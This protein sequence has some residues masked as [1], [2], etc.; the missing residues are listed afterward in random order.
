MG[1]NILPSTFS[2]PSDTE[3]N[4]GKRERVVT[5]YKYGGEKQDETDA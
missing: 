2:M 4:T 5:N 3:Y 1:A